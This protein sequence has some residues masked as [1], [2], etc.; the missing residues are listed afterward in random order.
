MAASAIN[1]MFATS[2]PKVV[3]K[4]LI[5][6]RHND[7]ILN[8][9]QPTCSDITPCHPYLQPPQS[10]T[11]GVINKLFLFHVVLTNPSVNHG[12]LII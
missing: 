9:S 12:P 3:T 4:R 7:T 2:A 11:L 10:P 5:A 1:S 6:R 8:T